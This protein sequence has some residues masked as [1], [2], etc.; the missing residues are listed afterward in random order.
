M[1]AEQITDTREFDSNTTGL[2]DTIISSVATHA[3][4]PDITSVVNGAREDHSR[5]IKR[6]ND[7]TTPADRQDRLRKSIRDAVNSAK[8]KASRPEKPKA[9]G[10]EAPVGAPQVWSAEAKQ[11]W[12]ELP[13]TVKLATAREQKAYA[14]SITPIAEKFSEIEKVLAPHRQLYSTRGISDAAAVGELFGWWHHLRGPQRAQAFAH[15]MAETGTPLEAIY[16]VM[17]GQQPTYPA[18][19]GYQP[20]PEIAAAQAQQTLAEFGKGRTHFSNADVRYDMG[21]LLSTQGHNYVTADGNINLQKAY[22]DVVRNRGLG[23]SSNRSK[24]N[25]A[26]S[27][28][29]GS[30]A[31]RAEETR[32]SAGIRG[33][34]KDAFREARDR[35]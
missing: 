9:N 12:S 14:E 28:R 1:P 31:G 27:P 4:D 11:A 29:G 20:T 17:N 35:D 2:R 8:Q 24:R 10:V 19:Q 33:S 5:E 25:A 13:D 21:I 16:G 18:Q 23:G 15:L 32:R 34:I 7:D 22:D 26:V 6:R 3:D 30:P